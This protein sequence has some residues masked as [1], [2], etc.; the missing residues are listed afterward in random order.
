MSFQEDVF[1]KNSLFGPNFAHFP[2]FPADMVIFLLTTVNTTSLTPEKVVQTWG[3]T[4]KV[5]FFTNI[6]KLPQI[7]RNMVSQGISSKKR[8]KKWKFWSFFDMIGMRTY[9]F[10]DISPD[11]HNK[12]GKSAKFCLFKMIILTKIVFLDL[13]LPISRYFPQICS[14]FG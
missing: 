10:D 6:W 14:I 11:M 13:I 4:Q 1:D 3:K 8:D 5:S 12:G 9:C 7:Y 2:L